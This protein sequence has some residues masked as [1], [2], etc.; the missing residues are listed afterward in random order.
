MTSNREG[1]GP[2]KALG[3][4]RAR[5][6]S[7]IGESRLVDPDGNGEIWGKTERVVF[8]A[9][10]LNNHFGLQV[11]S[12]AEVADEQK[13]TMEDAFGPEGDLSPFQVP[14]S[15]EIQGIVIGHV[16]FLDDPGE[17]FRRHYGKQ[18][19]SVPQEHSTPGFGIPGHEYD[20]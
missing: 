7:R 2:Y 12:E 11:G 5:G 14:T 1:T 10:A 8:V 18:H 13:R 20:D 19:S 16:I 3:Y 15:D 17:V 9:N 4:W 6:T